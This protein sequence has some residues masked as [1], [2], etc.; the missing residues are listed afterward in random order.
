MPEVFDPYATLLGLPPGPR[1]PDYY[2]LL[3]LAPFY[4]DMRA[5]AASAEHRLA[6]LQQHLAGPYAAIAS[7][8]INELAAARNLLLNPQAKAAYDAEL[9]RRMQGGMVP[10]YAQMQMAGAAYG[11]YGQPAYG[12]GGYAQQSK[13]TEPAV[14]VRPRRFAPR[15]NSSN[16]DSKLIFVTVAVMAVLG[17][18]GFLVWKMNQTTPVQHHSSET[19]HVPD[20]KPATTKETKTKPKAETPETA[21]VTKSKQP[22]ARPPVDSQEAEAVQEALKASRV[23]ISDR[24]W[25]LAENNLKKAEGVAKS[26]ASK[27]EIENV[28]ALLHYTKSYWGVVQ[29]AWKNM[30]AGN[31]LEING[32][33]IVIVEVL[34]EKLIIRAAGQNREYTVERMPFNFALHL[35][36]AWLTKGDPNSNLFLA[37]FHLT[38]YKG[39][40]QRARQLLNQAAQSG[41]DVAA[42][43]KELALA[44]KK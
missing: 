9:Y 8:L 10:Q 19:V 2:Q 25:T 36:E 18:G 29:S 13:P 3:G 4:P 37:A 41:I 44:E 39:N 12:Q 11:N 6:H 31:E 35:G 22:V 40:R 42:L 34:P 33:T 21:V 27:E 5:I 23:A 30:T 43:Q 26:H 38:D 32:E 24:K 15:T 16:S 28:R 14:S 7:Q 20:V 17:V 1:P